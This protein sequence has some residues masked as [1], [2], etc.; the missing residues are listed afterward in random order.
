M[1]PVIIFNIYKLLWTSSTLCQHICISMLFSMSLHTFLGFLAY[2]LF[3]C[4]HAGID[5]YFL[6]YYIDPASGHLFR[7]M[8]EVFRYLDTGKKGRRASKPKKQGAINL[9]SR[10]DSLSVSLLR[11]LFFP[12]L[13]SYQIKTLFI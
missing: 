10:H 4:P 6:Q 2:C 9:E 5:V 7:S 3:S 8:K 11:F 1:V 13:L 12:V